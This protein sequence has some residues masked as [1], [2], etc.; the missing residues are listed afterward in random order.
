MGIFNPREFNKQR[1]DIL[2][3]QLRDY[4]SGQMGLSEAEQRGIATQATA[5]AGMAAPIQARAL[6]EQIRA[7][8]EAQLMAALQAQVSAKKAAALQ[9]SAQVPD[10]AGAL[11]DVSQAGTYAKANAPSSSAGSS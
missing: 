10:Y 11:A 1:K 6:S 2:A 4:Y 3:G 9:V 5:A 8:K 7:Q